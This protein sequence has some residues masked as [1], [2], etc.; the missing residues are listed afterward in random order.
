[1]S[2]LPSLLGLIPL[3]VIIIHLLQLFKLMPLIASF[4]SFGKNSEVAKP[5]SLP[6]K[7]IPPPWNMLEVQCIFPTTSP[8]NSKLFTQ[9]NFPSFYVM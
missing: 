4:H 2:S 3:Y 5:T 1:M 9:A 7:V 6:T 8:L